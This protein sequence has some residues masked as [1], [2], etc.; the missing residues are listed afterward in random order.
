MATFR[1]VANLHV[2]IAPTPFFVAG[3]GARSTLGTSHAFSVPVAVA[4]AARLLAGLTSEARVAAT[5]SVFE[6]TPVAAAVARAKLH[7][8][9]LACKS[10]VA[11]AFAS[12]TPAVHVAPRIACNLGA[13]QA[14]IT[15][16]TLAGPVEADSV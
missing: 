14:R 9:V 11:R 10:G 5:G 13:V 7:H 1:G 16:V 3:A 8:A 12:N 2:A 4:L 6:A 15:V